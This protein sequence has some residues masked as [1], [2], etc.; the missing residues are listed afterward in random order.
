MY[1]ESSQDLLIHEGKKR[2][3]SLFLYGQTVKPIEITTGGDCRII[4]IYLYPHVIRSL[5]GVEAHEFTDT[6]LDFD[7]LP[8]GEVAKTMELCQEASIERQVYLL[9]DFLIKLI[10][11]NNLSVES[12]LQ[13]VTNKMTASAGSVTLKSLQ[14]DLRVSERT[15]ERMFLRHVGITPRLYAR[16]CRFNATIEQL[17]SNQ[18]TKLTDIAFDNGFADQ[19]HFIRTFKEFTGLTPREYLAS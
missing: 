15:F 10:T 4:V 18:Q 8:F 9:S 19:S 6:C 3:P 12:E 11:R 5:F 2:L 17:K 1:Q 13:Y 7:L 14:K 16:I